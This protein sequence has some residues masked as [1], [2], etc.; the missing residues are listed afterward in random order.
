MKLLRSIWFILVVV[1]ATAFYAGWAVLAS[2]VGIR[3]APNNVYDRIM[4]NWSRLILW[5]HRVRVVVDGA[6]RVD[7]ARSYVLV[8][9]HTSMVDI[10]VLQVAIPLSFRY[11]AKQEL[12]R[13]P[14][15]GRGMEGAGNI[16]LDRSNRSSAFA[17]YEEAARRIRG[18]LSAMVFAEGTRSRDGRLLPFKK[19]PFIL[20]ISA[21]VPVVPVVVEGAFERTPKGA[22][23]VRPGTVSVR[24]GEPISTAGMTPGDRGAL[25]DRV[26]AA[27]LGLGAR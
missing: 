25:A 15:L 8:A 1:P 27:M 20:A 14:V 16:F 9:N 4:R 11:V 19:G 22:R 17:A 10:W 6:D 23:Y 3:Y 5:A 18:G 24:I 12:S 26:R 2:W 7:P 21:G 13:V